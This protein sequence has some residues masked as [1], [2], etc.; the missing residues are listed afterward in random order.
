MDQKEKLEKGSELMLQFGKAYHRDGSQA[1]D[2][3]DVVLQNCEDGQV[4]FV[5]SMSR[6]ALAE[7]I[8]TGKVVLYSQSRKCLWPKGKTSG[9]ELEVKEIFVNCEQNCLLIKVELKGGGACH[10]KNKKGET[11]KSCFYRSIDIFPKVCLNRKLIKN[12]TI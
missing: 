1:P 12:Q 3:V 5:A 7:T 11:M 8:K 4:L 2:L 6:E 10:V 9:D